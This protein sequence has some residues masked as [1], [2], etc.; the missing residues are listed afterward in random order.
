MHKKLFANFIYRL[1]T[2]G[3]GN[4]WFKVLA[5]HVIL[6]LTGWAYISSL[7]IMLKLWMLGIPGSHHGCVYALSSTRVLT[8][9]TFHLHYHPI[10]GVKMEILPC[11]CCIQIWFPILLCSSGRDQYIVSH[12]VILSRTSSWGAESFVLHAWQ[13]RTNISDTMCRVSEIRGK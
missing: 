5:F 13:K 10:I 6:S 9:I 1:V 7:L 12:S 3:L 8:V 2:R 4:L 11:G